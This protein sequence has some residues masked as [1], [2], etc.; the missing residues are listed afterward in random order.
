MIKIIVAVEENQV[1]RFNYEYKNI[2]LREMVDELK[3]DTTK[4]G[5]VLMD[6]VPKKLNEK[7]IDDTEIYFLPILS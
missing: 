6:G 7:L 2:T 4:I 1:N 3:I 5:A